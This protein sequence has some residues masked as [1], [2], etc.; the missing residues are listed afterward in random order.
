MDW[1]AAAVEGWPVVSARCPGRSRPGIRRPPAAPFTS[2]QTAFPVLSDYRNVSFRGTAMDSAS[3]IAF[4]MVG[5]ALVLVAG[6]VGY[7]QYVF[8]QL[9]DLDA[10]KRALGASG[11]PA[12]GP[13]PSRSEYVVE[14]DVPPLFVPALPASVSQ[15]L[16]ESHRLDDSQQC[17]GHTVVDV[18]GS[19]YVQRVGVDGKPIRCYGGMASAPLR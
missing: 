1:T 11:L 2:L 17:I 8:R 14:R 12:P 18:H 15:R 5:A 4:G 10:I 7:N 13:P 3:K 16:T 19:A 9:S 6:Y